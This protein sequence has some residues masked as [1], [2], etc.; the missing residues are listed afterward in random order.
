MVTMGTFFD[1]I[2]DER[3]NPLYTGVREDVKQSLACV[4]EDYAKF[5]WVYMGTHH[6]IVSV[7]EYLNMYT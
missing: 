1:T 5:L 3:I 2:L 6:K 4:P 7:W